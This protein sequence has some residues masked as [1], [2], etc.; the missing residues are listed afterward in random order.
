MLLRLHE[1][2]VARSKRPRLPFDWNRLRNKALLFGI[3]KDGACVRQ[4]RV[5]QKLEEKSMESWMESRLER[6]YVKL[7][8]RRQL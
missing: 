4:P 2:E 7:I 1:R 3:Y 5:V 6:F 8:S